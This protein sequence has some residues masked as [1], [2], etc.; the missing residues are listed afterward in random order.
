MDHI[1]TE[2]LLPE[3]KEKPD[4]QRIYDAF[5]QA[6]KGREFASAQKS[7]KALARYRAT[8]GFASEDL[9]DDQVRRDFDMLGLLD[10]PPKLKTKTKPKTKAKNKA[11]PGLKN[12]E[13][14]KDL[15]TSALSASEPKL[16]TVNIKK[17]PLT[18]RKTSN[19]VPRRTRAKRAAVPQVQTPVVEKSPNKEKEWTPS[20]IPPTLLRKT[21]RTG[22]MKT[23]EPASVQ[24]VPVTVEDHI[25]PPSLSFDLSR[26][27]FN[28]G[29]YQLQ[30]P[31]S[32]VYNFDPYLADIMQPQ[33]FN[34]A[35]LNAYITA[36]EDETLLQIARDQSKKYIGSTS[37]MSGAMCHFHYLLSKFR[38]LN[39]QNLSQNI[40]ANGL[41]TFAERTR[42]PVAINLRWRDGVYAVDA[43][44]TYDTPNILMMLGKSMEKLLTLEKDKFEE[45]RKIQG[46]DG[47]E[48]TALQVEPETYHYATQGDFLMRSQ[49]DA[50][51]KRL[52]GTGTFD[53]KTRAVAG[54]R[55]DMENWQEGK[56]YEIKSRF[57]EWES[58]EKEYHD[59]MRSTM[60]KYMIQ[61]RMGRMDGIFV[62][63]HN[64][65]RLFG[66]QYVPISEM[67]L[68]LHGQSDP[69]LGDQEFRTSVHMMNEVF[70]MATKKFPEQT[71]RFHFESTLR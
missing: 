41:R 21:A 4:Q 10:G 34:Y 42:A 45:Y 37:S 31:R 18:F 11:V 60:L 43:D 67:D 32:R 2:K 47:A 6:Y 70:D 51:D 38:P 46:T 15:D 53:L 23:F 39:I 50:H 64:I 12:E 28:P 65:S 40:A 25:D 36:S 16:E 59:M 56:Q 26:V 33:D 27:L 19:S 54:I 61:V 14:R 35:A 9:K 17:V 57:G 24:T 8:T 58:Y 7:I 71:L 55:F 13:V 5:V 20:I 49:L 3:W 1:L 29:I 48:K 22:Q 44:K 30:D 52:P 69:T 68:G 66:F 62:A 63:Y